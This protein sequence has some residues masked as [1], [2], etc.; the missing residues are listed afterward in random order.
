MFFCS[1]LLISCRATLCQSVVCRRCNN[2]YTV[3]R[4]S[5]SQHARANAR[6]KKT[7]R[8][9]QE[10]WSDVSIG[11]RRQN[12][13]DPGLVSFD[14]FIIR[15]QHTLTHLVGRRGPNIQTNQAAYIIDKGQ[16][17]VFT[18]TLGGGLTPACV[19]VCVCRYARNCMQP[20]RSHAQT[21]PDA[22]TCGCRA[23][24]CVS[25]PHASHCAKA[26]AAVGSNLSS[27]FLVQRVQSARRDVCRIVR[28]TRDE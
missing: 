6:T 13:G 27:I 7:A 24:I 12:S 15:L 10:F 9:L 1:L 22:R 8:V 11:Y 19:C 2:V 18:H 5:R 16:E 3:D 23:S 14:V 17:N 20:P 21:A 25:T 4:T 26:A 28:S